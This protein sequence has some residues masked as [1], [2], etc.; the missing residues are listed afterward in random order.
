MEKANKALAEKYPEE[1]KDGNAQE[2]G[3]KTALMSGD[4]ESVKKLTR[5]YLQTRDS[6][7]NRRAL[8]LIDQ[9]TNDDIVTV[10][11]H[12]TNAADLFAEAGSDTFGNLSATLSLVEPFLGVINKDNTAEGK[13]RSLVEFKLNIAAQ[14][15]ANLGPV[16]SLFTFAHSIATGINASESCTTDTGS[17]GDCTAALKQELPGIALTAVLETI[18]NGHLLDIYSI[19]KMGQKV[20]DK[21]TLK[22]LDVEDVFTLGAAAL[23]GGCA[24]ATFAFPVAAVPC[25]IGVKFVEILRD[26]GIFSN[27]TTEKF[28]DDVLGTIEKNP[29]VKRILP[30]LGAVVTTVTNIGDTFVRAT[31][32]VVET[33]FKGAAKVLNVLGGIAGGAVDLIFGNNRNAAIVSPRSRGGRY[34]RGGHRRGAVQRIVQTAGRV[35]HDIGNE[36]GKGIHNIFGRLR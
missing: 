13:F 16:G 3:F 17:R 21:G 1:F 4:K 12:A 28:L 32:R 11:S 20:V 22:A 9:S 25:A 23:R 7:R 34:G 8:Q 14:V 18:G 6:A 30:V 24:V 10:I 27:P 2:N 33:V 29:I 19:F 5:Q 36:I 35:V 15:T 31:G 26:T